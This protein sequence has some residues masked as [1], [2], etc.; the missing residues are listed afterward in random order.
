ME[1]FQPFHGSL[2]P[3][4][5]RSITALDGPVVITTGCGTGTDALA[6][7]FLDSGASAYVAPVGAPFGYASVF[8]PLFLFYELT[9]G[10]TLEQ[11]VDR[12]TGHDAELAM[13]RLWT[14]SNR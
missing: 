1:G 7:A 11:A 2:G 4:E 6:Q 9:E 14:A 8:A 3:D 5:V 10:R 13:W 12:L